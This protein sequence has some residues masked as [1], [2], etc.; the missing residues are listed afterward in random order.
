MKTFRVR[1]LWYLPGK[2]D[3]LVAGTLRFRPAT[4]LR[5]SLTGSFDSETILNASDQPII[6]GF[7]ETGY[8][9]CRVV[10]LNSASRTRLSISMPGFQTEEFRATTAYFSDHPIPADAVF[11]G[12]RVRLRHLN[13]WALAGRGLT[14]SGIINEGGTFSYEKPQ[15]LVAR[16]D[17][18]RVTLDYGLVARRSRMRF[19]AAERATLV[20]ESDVAIDAGAVLRRCV[21]P[22][23]ELLIFATDGPVSIRE[24]DLSLPPIENNDGSSLDGHVPFVFSPAMGSVDGS[25]RAPELLFTIADVGDRFDDL[26]REWIELREHKEAFFNAFFGL[27]SSPPRFGEVRFSWLLHCISLLAVADGAAKVPPAAHTTDLTTRANAVR[28]LMDETASLHQELLPGDAETF[29]AKVLEAHR[30]V[31]YGE[32]IDGGSLR[33]MEELLKGTVRGWLLLR[34]S[35]LAPLAANLLRKNQHL[36][37]AKTKI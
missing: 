24:V 1:G 31:E 21:R 10:T 6:Y 28:W 33:W 16:A 23:A 30:R 13:H 27:V 34:L 9:G 19:R 12:C 22:L 14:G 17:G 29:I 3:D 35:V 32:S 36:Q 2:D 8:R 7:V 11:N 37:F 25:E 26:I 4:G 15:A 5:L 18:L 20:V